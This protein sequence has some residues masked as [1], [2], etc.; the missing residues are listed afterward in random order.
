MNLRRYN[1]YFHTHTISGIFIC[2]ILFVIF[3]AG[4]YS[5][6]KKDI[7]AWQSGT[8]S[9]GKENVKVNYRKLIDSLDQKYNMQGRDLSIY[10]QE[11]SLNTY[12]DMSVTKDSTLAPKKKKH[13]LKN[14]ERGG[15][16]GRRR[17]GD[18]QYFKYNVIKGAD[19]SSYD[20]SYDMG[21]FLYRLHFLAQLN[22]VPIHLGAPFGYLLAGLVA[23]VFLFALITG[24]LLHWDKIVSNFFVFRPW[25]KAKTVWTDSHTALGIIGFPYQFIYALTGIILIFNTAIIAPFNYL[26][27]KGKP[28]A[29]YKDLDYTDSREYNYGYSKINKKVDIT[30]YV[31]HTRNLWHNGFIQR[32]MIKNYGDTA[33]HIVVEGSAN[34]KDNFSGTGRIIYNI[35]HNKVVYHKSP[36]TDVTYIDRIR[37]LIYRLHFGNYGGYGLKILYFILGMMGCVVIISGILIWLVGREKNTIPVHKR[38]FNFWLA[39][40]FIAGCM[41][42]FPVT[43]LT[44][45]AVK[46]HG[47]TTREFTFHFYFYGW[48]LL[49]IFYI[50]RKNLRTTTRET[51][52]LGS[53]LSLLIPVA[54]GI[55]SGNWIWK[56]Y[57]SGATDILIFDLFSITIAAVGLYSFY[58]I[59]QRDK[60]KIALHA[61]KTR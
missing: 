13:Q 27:Y 12:V 37:S 3:F 54:N 44:F 16:R 11:Q 23:F 18:A 51:I 28:G 10:F 48:L 22:A 33:M 43:S 7:T 8:T 36:L 61:L 14:K 6:F 58:K 55:C 31:E 15:G 39:N 53:V 9:K 47:A 2:A 60:Q 29:I 52:L 1:I 40:I 21:E 26:Y 35:Q 46:I 49:S 59:Q 45:I 50:I 42:M 19:T 57:A 5:F 38:K 24:L 4:S 20:K 34:K 32:V 17:E 25:S 56:T 30:A 41:T